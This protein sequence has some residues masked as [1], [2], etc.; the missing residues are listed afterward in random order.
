[1]K[2]KVT[3]VIGAVLLALLI[4][5]GVFIFINSRVSSDQVFRNYIEMSSKSKTLDSVET[6]KGTGTTAEIKGSLNTDAKKMLITGELTCTG[7]LQK[8]EVSLKANMQVENE[9]SYLKL[10]S[11]T[12]QI[13]QDDGTVLDLNS[14]YTKVKD[15][16]YLITDT[17]PQ[18]KAQIDSG[19]YVFNS[20]VV[21]P[22]YDNDKL[23][24]ALINNKAFVYTSVVRTGKNYE[25]KLV[26][27][28]SAYLETLKEVFPNLDKPDLILDN[29][30]EDKST[31][32][33]TLLVSK[34]G[35]LIK[36]QLTNTNVCPEIMSTFVGEGTEGLAKDLSGV[37]TP[38]AKGSITIT[39]IT[40]S[41]PIE[42]MVNDLVF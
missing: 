23:V 9:K 11:I 20:A 31:L 30:F 34:N 1:M 41:K 32:E 14:V 29:L 12:G 25:I 8:K 16:W 22:S 40:S 17:D 4:G 6:D 38:K 2:K 5:A 33:S 18:A 28:K 15:N 35:D 36:E 26:A 24:N 37:N 10:N 3:V 27:N 42:D 13:V 21:A 19:V 7:Q 39:P